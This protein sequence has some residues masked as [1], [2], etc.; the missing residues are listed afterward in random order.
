MN[1]DTMSTLNN[2]TTAYQ[3][4]QLGLEY[5]DIWLTIKSLP[6]SI[7]YT[8]IILNTVGVASHTI[9][10]YLLS[11][12]KRNRAPNNCNNMVSYT[13]F[14]LLIMLSV[15]E[16]LSGLIQIIIVAS[17]EGKLPLVTKIFNLLFTATS[18]V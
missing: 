3:E 18:V 13:N 4:V 15:C 5:K 14:K 11:T 10:L 8:S 16:L 6:N 1:A 12:A 9:G 17:Y 2:L 7:K